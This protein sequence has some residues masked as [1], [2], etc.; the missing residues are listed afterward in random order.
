MLRVYEVK[1]A[2]NIV[3]YF[4]FA[5]FDPKKFGKGRVAKKLAISRDANCVDGQAAVDMLG[6]LEAKL[7]PN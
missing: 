5:N 3:V 6:L 2:L 1:K 4:N 7:G